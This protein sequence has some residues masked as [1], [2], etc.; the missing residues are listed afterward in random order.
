MVLSVTSIILA[1]LS[2][3]TDQ[4]MVMWFLSGFGLSGYEVTTFVYA[5]E[6][7]GIF[8]SK[9][10]SLCSHSPYKKI[11]VLGSETS[12]IIFCSLLGGQDR[13]W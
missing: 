3:S 7:S 4:F 10:P 1:G 12:A 6:I 9:Y 13:Y 2:Q 11:K 5:S 8:F